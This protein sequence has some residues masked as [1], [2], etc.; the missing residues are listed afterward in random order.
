MPNNNILSMKTIARLF[1]VA[2]MTISFVACNRCS[3]V[4][5]DIHGQAIARDENG[6]QLDTLD[7]SSDFSTKRSRNH[8]GCVRKASEM[9]VPQR[10]R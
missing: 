10:A 1:I 3:T 2:L 6:E 5:R 4:G 8:F 7:T 9:G